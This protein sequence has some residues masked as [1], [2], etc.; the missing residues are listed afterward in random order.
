M[1]SG[2]IGC[3]GRFNSHLWHSLMWLSESEKMSVGQKWMESLLWHS[4]IE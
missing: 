3:C 2:Q 4:A 1:N